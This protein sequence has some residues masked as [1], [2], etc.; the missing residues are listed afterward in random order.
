MEKRK[1][2]EKKN[3]RK[4]KKYETDGMKKVAKHTKGKIE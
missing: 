2:Y 3:R 4:R 1:E